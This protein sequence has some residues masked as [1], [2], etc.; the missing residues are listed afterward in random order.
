M[1]EIDNKAFFSSVCVDRCKGGCCDPWWGIISYTVSKHVMQGGLEGFGEELARG[2][3]ARAKR[4]I[5]KYVTKEAGARPLFGSPEKYNVTVRN[6]SVGGRSIT[7]ELMAM[8]A[9]R[10][11]FLS[12]DKKCGIHPSAVG[13]D[14]RPPHCGYMGSPGA[15]PNELGY[16]RVI[17]AA[18]AGGDSA[19]ALEIERSASLAH[20]RAGTDSPAQ[21]AQAVMERL[22]DY[23]SKNAPDLL[24]RRAGP[25]PGRNDP[26]WCGSSLKYKKCHGRP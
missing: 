26:C 20:W 6:I 12:P 18:S 25:L 17:H 5:E 23:C 16:C 3:E 10:C 9:F 1:R 4:I 8:F 22:R 14:I 19:E 2:I 24:N 7:L 13:S 21:A 15:R 11:R